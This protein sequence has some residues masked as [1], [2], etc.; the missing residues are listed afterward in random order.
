MRQRA[1][2]QTA[3]SMQRC[4]LGSCADIG[5]REGI[6]HPQHPSATKPVGVGLAMQYVFVT[7]VL[8]CNGSIAVR[9][10]YC[11][12]IA[13]CSVLASLCRR[14]PAMH[15]P[16]TRYQLP[17]QQL[18]S[19]LRVDRNADQDFL[20]LPRTSQ[21]LLGPP[22]TSQDLSFLVESQQNPSKISVDSQEFRL[23]L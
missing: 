1:S 11:C 17:T 23:Y 10:I 20:R 14:S 9:E 2:L 18:S 4:Q 7:H 22:R 21:V 6:L 8:L 3:N 12:A 13:I 16:S 5:A 15:W 19:Q